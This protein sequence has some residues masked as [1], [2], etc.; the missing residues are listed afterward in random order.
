MTRP[1]IEELQ[2]LAEA[3]TPGPWEVGNHASQ[4]TS[5]CTCCGLIATCA[6]FGFES[7]DRETDAAQHYNSDY[8]AAA[9]P[10]A[11]LEL[12]AYVKRLEREN[13]SLT[14]SNNKLVADAEILIAMLRDEVTFNAYERKNLLAAIEADVAKA[15]DASH[16]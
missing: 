11:V 14:T 8:I 10:A 12:L 9:N 7:G 15:K 16:D 6:L 1:N 3:A 5:S 13:E 4:V 2:R